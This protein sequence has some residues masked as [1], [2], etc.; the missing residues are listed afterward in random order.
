MVVHEVSEKI[1]WEELA[2]KSAPVDDGVIPDHRKSKTEGGAKQRFEKFAEKTKLG[3][4][5]AARSPVRKLTPDDR[6]KIES[7]YAGLALAAAMPTPMQNL[8]ASEMLAAQAAACADSWMALAEN[9][10]AVRRMVLIVI[11]GGAWGAVV[12]AHVPIIISFLPQ[13]MRSQ[14]LHMAVRPTVPDS[15]EGL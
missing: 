6:E 9:N 5:K 3:A 10:D 8:E 2:K 15:P 12:T 11:E 4:N 13:P 14:M 1:D 7:F